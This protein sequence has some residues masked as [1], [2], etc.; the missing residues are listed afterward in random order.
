MRF[1]DYVAHRSLEDHRRLVLAVT[2]GLHEARLAV[3]IVGGDGDVE[4][5]RERVAQAI[6]WLEDARR[7]LAGPGEASSE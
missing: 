3:E 7:L 5:L 2:T 6:V 4:T 1:S